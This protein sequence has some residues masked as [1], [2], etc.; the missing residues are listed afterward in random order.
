MEALAQVWELLQNICINL[1]IKHCI[2]RDYLTW[3][4]SW[5]YIWDMDE[6][7]LGNNKCHAKA[8]CTNTA[9]SYHCVCLVGY[10]GDGNICK[11]TFLVQKSQWG[12]SQ[13]EGVVLG[14]IWPHNDSFTIVL[15]PS[16]LQRREL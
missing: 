10:S 5:L 9:G 16:N 4:K 13:R 12:R 2:P 3:L 15:T 14:S 1:E 8:K 7:F 11:G 6:C